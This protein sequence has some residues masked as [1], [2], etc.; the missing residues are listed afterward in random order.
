MKTQLPIILF[1]YLFIHFPVS[2][3]E[4]D[5]EKIIEKI[6][7]HIDP[8]HD[9]SVDMEI[10]VNVDFIKIPVKHATMYFKQPDKVKFK[11]KEFIMLPK[12]GVDNSF[13]KILNEKYTALYS[14]TDT[15]GGL[16]TYVVKLIP[17]DPKSDII[18]ATWWVDTT[19][20][21]IRRI[22]NN[23]RK[24]GTFVIDFT[25]DDPSLNLP[26]MLKISFEVSHMKLPFMFLGKSANEEAA[27]PNDEGKHSGNVIIRF[28]NYKINLKLS[29]ELFEE[30]EKGND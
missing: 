9:Y 3:Q 13:R 20:Y 10:T 6:K 25:Y 23:T 8:I 15:L 14:G 19:D 28:S 30:K 17:A 29:D 11:S 4:P 2:G 16:E 26:T 18:M 24:E 5:P 21:L 22:E 7:Q 12:K 1:A 27:L